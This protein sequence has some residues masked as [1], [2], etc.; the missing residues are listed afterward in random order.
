MT[1][2]VIGSDVAVPVPRVAVTPAPLNVTAVAPARPVPVIVADAVAPVIPTAGETLVITGPELATVKPLNG[3]ESPVVFVT[4]IVRSPSAAPD[5]SVT[6]IGKLVSVL[7]LPMTA[8][9]PV[10]E[11]VTAVDVEKFTPVIT[12]LTV[13]PG[14]PQFCD[15][16]VM[17]GTDAPVPET[18][19]VAVLNTLEVPMK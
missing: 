19:K 11:K 2:T 16:D 9:T 7:P 13:P 10:P 5:V 15:I 18:I 17:T 6:V 12:V 3:V 1:V 14:V 8:V 4:V